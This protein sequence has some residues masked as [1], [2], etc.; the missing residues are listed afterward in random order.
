M[1]VVL[2]IQNNGSTVGVIANVYE[3]GAS[4]ENKYH[5]VL[6]YAAKSDLLTHAA[7]MLNETGSEIKHEFY[8][9]LPPPPEPEPEPEPEV[10]EES[11]TEPIELEDPINSEE[12][13]EEEPV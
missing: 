3:D 1:F 2:E 9:H 4:A 12:L 7:V 5:T 6:A 11:S 8:R 13:S 10:I